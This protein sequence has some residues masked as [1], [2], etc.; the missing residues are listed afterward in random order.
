M[1]RKDGIESGVVF[2]SEIR[3][4][5]FTQIWNPDRRFIWFFFKWLF[6]L[7]ILNVLID[8]LFH[9]LKFLKYIKHYFYTLYF[10]IPIYKRF[11]G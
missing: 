1:V 11:R 6:I 4:K 9:F 8:K 7:V 3:K 5:R 10:I 2:W